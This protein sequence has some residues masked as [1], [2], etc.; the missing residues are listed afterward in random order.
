[1]NACLSSLLV[2]ASLV[3]PPAGPDTP[4][5]LREESNPGKIELRTPEVSVPMHWLMKKP[6]VDVKINGKGPYRFFL[7]TGAQGSVL[8]QALAEDLKLPVL[9]DGR[10]G[11]PGGK[12]LPAKKV[13]LDR[14]EVGDAVLSAV[15]AYAFDRSHLDRGKDSP[16]GVLS[17]GIFPG[18]LVTLDYPQSRLVIRRGQLP[19]PDSARVFTYD[20]KRPLPELR[21][22]VAGQQVDV[23]LDSGAPGGITLPLKLAERLP[24][25]SKPVEVA[26][27]RR[28][29]QEVVILGAKLNGQVKL[30]RYV[31]ENPDLRFQDIPNAPGH[32]GYEFLRRFAVTL[33]AANHRVQ[34]DQRPGAD[35]QGPGAVAPPPA[36]DEAAPKL[37][38]TPAGRQLK[39]WLSAFN[40]G[41][42][43]TIRRFLSANLAKAAVQEMSVPERVDRELFVYRDTGGLSVTKIEKST[44]QEIVVV[45]K[46]KRQD[47]R[48][49][50]T[51]KVAEEAPH[52]ITGLG[53]RVLPSPIAHPGQGKLSAREIARELEA[54]V[55]KQAAADEFS[56]AVLVA[57]DGQVIFQKAYG[58]AN[59]TAN[60]P[61]RVETKFNLGSMNKMLTAV[62][63]MQLAEQGKL[64]VTDTVGKHLPDYPN[65]EVANRVTIHQLL[66]HTSGLGDFFNEKFFARDR[67]LAKVADYLPYFVDEPLAFPPGTKWKYSNAGYIVLGLIV[68]KVSGQSYYDYVRDHIYRPAGML[69]TS[70]RFPDAEKATIAAGYTRQGPDGPRNGPRRENTAGR[71]EIGSSAGGGYSTV[72]DLLRFDQALRGNRL[73]NAKNT[74]LMTTAT[75]LD[76]DGSGYAYGFGNCRFNGQRVLGHNGGAPGIGAQFD[77]Y[78]DLGYTVVILSNY[79]YRDMQAV[80][81]KTRELI[82]RE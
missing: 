44:A 20:A 65:K 60:I 74:A 38:D 45:A 14:L 28:V 25:A 70:H 82:A 2:L 6:M 53:I 23:H 35:N 46:M 50:I 57:K 34:L 80:V 13:R 39:A 24:L 49:R 56:G 71:P 10:V 59:R 47:K 7:D 15:P 76:E 75:K 42:A 79:D 8:D 48:T 3:G 73:L 41:D 1:M 51:L 37:P 43:D 64:A 61:N 12:G 54:F 62:A 36:K 30:G 81:E 63:V 17:A 4:V 22:S 31:L 19:A 67:P 18:F 16:R 68:A 58:L 69:N 9:G 32:V 78:R 33:D 5:I 11:S 52:P 27:G 21:L 26:R 55:D 29:D 72:A 77:S 66:T 40:S